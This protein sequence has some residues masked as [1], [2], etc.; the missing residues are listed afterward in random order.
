LKVPTQLQRS[1]IL[2]AGLVLLAGASGLFGQTVQNPDFSVPTTGLFFAHQAGVQTAPRPQSIRIYSGP[3][4]VNYTAFVT[5]PQGE[6]TGWLFLTCG[7]CG[8]ATNVA[9]LNGNTG[10][11]GENIT[12]SVSP[13]LAAR[14][15]P[16]TG[17]V[18]LIS[19]NRVYP[20]NVTYNVL[21]TAQLT[22]TPGS[23]PLL[24]VERVAAGTPTL[25]E[26]ITVGS[27]GTQQFFNTSI[28]NLTPNT[29]WLVVNPA[30]GI[31]G[32]S[33][34]QISVDTSKVP[35]GIDR[36]VAA[37]RVFIPGSTAFVTVPVTVKLIPASALQVAPTSARF[38]YQPGPAGTTQS[39]APKQ[40]TVTSSTGS[41]VTYS[42]AIGGASP[43]FKLSTTGSANP[44]LALTNLT[45]PNGFY[46]VPDV[47]AIGTPPVGTVLEAP[48]VITPANGTASQTVTA[49]LEITNQN[50]L[51][52]DRDVINFNYTLGGAD[53]A[54]QSM[55]VSSTGASQPFTTG[56]IFDVA[57]PV[58]FFRVDAL[59]TTT[60]AGVNVVPAM[61]II[62]TLTV[63]TYNGTI[64]L[65]PSLA[66]DKYQDISV[67][68]T[69]SRSGQLSVDT[70]APPAFEGALGAQLLPQRLVVTASDPAAPQTFTATCDYGSGTPVTCGTGSG[71]WLLV[72]RQTG[73]T[74]IPESST[75]IISVAPG[76]ITAAGTYTA[77][78]VLTPINVTNPVPVRVRVQ[79][80]VNAVQSVTADPARLDIVQVA[81]NVPPAQTIQIRTSSIAALSFIPTVVTPTADPAFVVVPLN[82]ISVPGP[83]QV[84]FNSASL[85]PRTEP[86][87]N[88]IVL[89]SLSGLAPV[90]IQVFLRV[91]TPSS[92]AAAP[93]SL[94][95]AF[96][97]GTANPPSQTINLTATGAAIPFSAAAI[98]QLGSWLSV[99]PA[100]GSTNAAGGAAT[101][102]TVS[103]NPTGLTAGTYN[104][105]I[106][107]TPTTPG[108]NPVVVNVT[109]TV[110]T[111]N[112]PNGLQV[113]NNASGL[114]RGISPGLFITIKGRN[115]APATGVVFSTVPAPT[116]LGEVRV[117]FDNVPAPLIYVGPAGDRNGDQINAVVPYG[118]GG[119]ASTNLVVEYKGIAS[120][121]IP[122]TIRET[123]P[124][125]YTA[126]Q[127][128]SGA[129]SLLNQDNSANAQNNPAVAGSIIQIYGTGEGG[130]SPNPGDGRAVPTTQ[131]FPTLLSG[132]VQVRINGRV[133]QVLYAGPSPG[134]LAGVFQVNAA[135]PADLGVTTA[136]TATLEVQIGNTTSQNG[137]TFWVRGPQ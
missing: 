104:G 83:L 34:V 135:V 3:A 136:T 20:I 49:R 18:T 82:S 100:S 60:P 11:D 133:A 27:T 103:V 109:L 53:F 63:G 119:R 65:T 50:L 102:L 123:D 71:A 126:N 5:Y 13:M 86:Y 23:I 106:S 55:L 118:I 124:G 116:T 72:D 81:N 68:L 15:T 127:S 43:Y 73:N 57:N 70:Y 80:K 24:T 41:A 10:S 17:V 44:A 35:A 52:S 40:I 111:P 42:V 87:R 6:V 89:N 54:G 94:S 122:L 7:T 79:Y 99:T 98:S 69:I 76:A 12:I 101:P 125:L 121:S 58:Q 97:T 31:T 74:A 95:F 105:N 113:S 48:V 131:P 62:R 66:A 61:E 2:A 46:I 129:A 112:P 1:S 90:T 108:T 30:S 29:G 75:L 132:P 117:L 25:I 114:S 45:T 14:G 77:S 88:D 85:T 39:P 32:V 51:V 47:T 8:G 21:S 134:L 59:G 22:V 96:T 128:G 115:M 107:V 19:G 64:R 9:T 37:V 120:Q 92:L 84:T 78:L 110:T 56:A 137:V 28:E 130:F 67:R 38:L 91:T 36:V 4:S 26:N 16:Y 33:P 93:A